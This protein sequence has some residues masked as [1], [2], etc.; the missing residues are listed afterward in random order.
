MSFSI[1]SISSHLTKQS[2]G[3]FF[4]LTLSKVSE[5]MAISRLS[6]TITWKREVKAK[7]EKVKAS[8]S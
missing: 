3:I 1:L 4:S 6:R 8:I 2:E 7:M 5:I